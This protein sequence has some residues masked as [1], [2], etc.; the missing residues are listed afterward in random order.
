MMPFKHSSDELT[1]EYLKTI[2]HYDPETGVWTWLSTRCAG[3][4]AGYY[5]N[6]GYLVIMIF[7]KNYKG[8]RLAFLYMTGKWPEKDVDHKDTNTC[9]NKWLNLRE[10]T[11]SQNLGNSRISKLNKSGFKG[12]SWDK[13]TNM[14][15]VNIRFQGKT[16]N[17]G[18]YT[19]KEEAAEVY[20]K[21]AE[22]LFKEFARTTNA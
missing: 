12:V 11:P 1:Q 2:L 3:E 8:H 4:L 17:L 20:K 10:A 6:Y 13:F 22:K 21:E 15:R 5:D 16:K 9:N 14:W 18:R 7:N 19:S